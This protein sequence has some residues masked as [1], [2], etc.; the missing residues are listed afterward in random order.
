MKP[1]KL[2]IDRKLQ[3]KL[4]QMLQEEYLFQLCK[5]GVSIIKSLF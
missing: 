1:K 3:E 2:N 5:K 4:I